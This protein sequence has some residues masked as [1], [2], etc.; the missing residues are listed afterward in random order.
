M[1]QIANGQIHDLALRLVQR[2]M[3]QIANGRL[4]ALIVWWCASVAHARQVATV[5]ETMLAP[6]VERQ[7]EQQRVYAAE[8][9]SQGLLRVQRQADEQQMI[10]ERDSF[11]QLLKVCFQ[12]IVTRN[13]FCC[14]TRFDCA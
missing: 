2:S 11:K 6:Y 9:T 12:C 4:R 1:I 10:G 5:L 3:I 7:Q 14:A 8:Q 13:T